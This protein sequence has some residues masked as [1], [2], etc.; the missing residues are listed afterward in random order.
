MTDEKALSFQLSN[1]H[2]QVTCRVDGTPYSPD[3]FN[4]ILTQL[5]RGMA[6]ATEDAPDCGGVRPRTVYVA[7]DSPEDVMNRLEELLNDDDD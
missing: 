2:I 6:K 3:V 5:V 4:D 7:G 1:A